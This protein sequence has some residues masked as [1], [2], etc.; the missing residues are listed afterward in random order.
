MPAHA[1]IHGFLEDVGRAAE[2][3]GFCKKLIKFF[4]ASGALLVRR[5]ALR[6]SA[7]RLQEG[8]Q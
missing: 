1:G 7:L 4:W 3:A 6:V 8:Q 5:N 2:I